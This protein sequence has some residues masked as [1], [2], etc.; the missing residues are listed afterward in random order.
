M[1]FVEKISPFLRTFSK[2]SYEMNHEHHYILLIVFDGGASALYTAENMKILNNMNRSELC[3][4]RL[5]K[6]GHLGR[7]TNNL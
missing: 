3:K 5:V 2:L 7:K 6:R 1:V 4:V